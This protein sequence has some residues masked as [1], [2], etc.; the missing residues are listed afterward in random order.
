VTAA[1]EFRQPSAPIKAQAMTRTDPGGT[2]M[3]IRISGTEMTSDLTRHTARAADGGGWTV[4]WLP[5]RTLT[6]SQAVTAMTIAEA[7]VEHAG[8]L[9]DN[10]SAWWLH[11]DGLAAG[12]GITGPCAVAEASLSPEG[13]ESL[14]AAPA[15]DPERSAMIGVMT[16][17]EAMALLAYVAGYAPAVF[18]AAVADRSD[19]FADELAERADAR[20]E[21]EY[22]ADP[23]GYCL[24]CGANVAHFIGYDGPRHFRG[25]HKLVTGTERRELFTPEDGHA[26]RVAWREAGAR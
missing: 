15:A 13:R 24:A 2:P 22:M 25:P 9:A 12:L 16:P 10:G 19:T 5:G 21:A 26:P 23:E 7:V 1:G 20:A 18:D 4:S 14:D 6:H 17:D 11:I 3:A 8:D